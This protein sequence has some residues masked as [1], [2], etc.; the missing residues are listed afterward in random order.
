V[1]TLYP[2][3][4][5]DVSYLF[6][7]GGRDHAGRHAEADDTEVG[8]AFGDDTAACVNILFDA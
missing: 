5:C 1:D 8:I 4:G 3:P 7:P 6:H 2:V